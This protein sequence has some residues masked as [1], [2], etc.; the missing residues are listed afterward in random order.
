MPRH[1]TIGDVHG[2]AADDV[3]AQ[4]LGDLHDQVVFDVVDRGIGDGDRV[5]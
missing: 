4:V 5:Q 2:D 1:Q 3:V